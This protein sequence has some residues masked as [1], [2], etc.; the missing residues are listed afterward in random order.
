MGAE[1]RRRTVAEVKGELPAVLLEEQPDVAAA[2]GAA[3]RSSR[4]Q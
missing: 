4:K 2:G 1:K 3:R